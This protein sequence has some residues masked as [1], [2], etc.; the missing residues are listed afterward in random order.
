MEKLYIS[1]FKNLFAFSS[2]LWQMCMIILSTDKYIKLQFLS[3][4]NTV[5]LSISFGNSSSSCCI[6]IVKNTVRTKSNLNFLW[7]QF[8]TLSNIPHI[9]LSVENEKNLGPHTWWAL[10]SFY[11]LYLNIIIWIN[12]KVLESLT[13]VISWPKLWRILKE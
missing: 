5:S 2:T 6:D 8:A 3:I 11:L 1:I 9:D 10:S 12:I 4:T 13:L 7:F